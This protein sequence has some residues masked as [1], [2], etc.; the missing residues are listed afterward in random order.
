MFLAAEDAASPLL[1]HEGI[2]AGGMLLDDRSS[3]TVILEDLVCYYPYIYRK[4]GGYLMFT[5]KPAKPDY[6]DNCWQLYRNLAPASA[7]R[8]DVFAN[9]TLGFAAGGEDALWAVRNVNAWMR[10]LNTEHYPVCASFRNSAAWVF[11]FKFEMNPEIVFHVTDRS[12]LEVLGGS[13]N[14]LSPFPCK[15]PAIYA[16]DSKVSVVMSMQFPRNPYEIILEDVRD[17]VR[18]VVKRSEFPLMG[19]HEAVPII[20]LLVNY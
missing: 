8:K 19:S 18:R 12:E 14:Q 10:G 15:N 5:S 2:T 7:P 13:V 9:S 11:G 4:S 1:L 20:P 6:R 16:E 17:G 3:R